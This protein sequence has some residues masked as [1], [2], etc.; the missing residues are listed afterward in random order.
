MHLSSKL[1]ISADLLILRL[2]PNLGLVMY[3]ILRFSG[4][5]ANGVRWFSGS[6]STLGTISHRYVLLYMIY[7]WLFSRPICDFGICHAR[8]SCR[9]EVTPQ[10]TFDVNRKSKAI[11]KANQMKGLLDNIRNRKRSPPLNRSRPSSSRNRRPR[12][13]QGMVR[14]SIDIT[15]SITI[16][17]LLL[18]LYTLLL[19]SFST[20]YL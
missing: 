10:G 2:M 15:T 19:T 13:T 9:A 8:H 12:G 20:A 11:I 1:L 17:A 16:I 18:V 5:R 6:V 4:T 14:D 3:T 7:I